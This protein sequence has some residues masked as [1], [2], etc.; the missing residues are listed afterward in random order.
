M[1][2]GRPLPISGEASEAVTAA[3]AETLRRV[4][5]LTADV[6][7]D[8]A[9]RTS[10]QAARW[11][12]AQLLDWHRRNDKPAWWDYFRLRKLT[13]EELVD[14]SEPIGDL[15]YVGVVGA[16]KKSARPSLH[17]PPAGPQAEWTGDRLAG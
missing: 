1:T 17:V 5:L 2:L 3:Q 15:T 11:L 7:V 6:P 13:P 16:E 14:E 10:D 12:L 8:P 4:E 9:A